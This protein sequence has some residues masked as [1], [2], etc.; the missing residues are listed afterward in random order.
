MVLVE[1]CPHNT[2]PVDVVLQRHHLVLSVG[3]ITTVHASDCGEPAISLHSHS[4]T[5][6]VGHCLL[7]VMSKGG[8]TTILVR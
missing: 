6:P 7:P 8:Q 4:L 3:K 2:V 5:G 1:Q